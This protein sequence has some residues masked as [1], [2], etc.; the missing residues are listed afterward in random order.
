M[1]KKPLEIPR[2]PS[3]FFEKKKN[4]QEICNEAN[5]NIQLFKFF[6][7]NYKYLKIISYLIINIIFS[8]KYLQCYSNF[9]SLIKLLIKLLKLKLNL[10]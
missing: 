4:L 10:N 7:F 9:V 2:N 5:E 8:H 3:K 1:L 6:L